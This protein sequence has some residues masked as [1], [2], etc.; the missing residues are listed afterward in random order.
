MP[1]AIPWLGMGTWEA[2]TTIPN[3]IRRTFC[4][5]QKKEK[6]IVTA[7]DFSE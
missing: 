6:E 5:E 1:E 7:G 3:L 4:L 2:R